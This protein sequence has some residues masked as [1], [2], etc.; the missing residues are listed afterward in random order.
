MVCLRMVLYKLL[1]FIF[2]LLF[3][4]K[5]IDNFV[6]P[7]M[8]PDFMLAAISGNY[9]VKNDKSRYALCI[10]FHYAFTKFCDT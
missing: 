5:D 10:L 1:H 9:H 3:S 8:L 7:E 2:Y 6:F 4:H